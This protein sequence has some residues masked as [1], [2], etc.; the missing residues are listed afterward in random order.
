MSV[1][2]STGTPAR[3]DVR[4]NDGPSLA[5]WV[6][7]SGPPLVLVHGSLADHTT[8]QPFVAALRSSVTTFSMDRRGF[9]GSGDGD[10]YTIEQDFADV[11]AVV[12]AVAV[13]TGGP[14]ALFGH[15]YGAGCAMGAATLTRNA[16]HLVLYEPG[17]G[18]A[19]RKG[20]IEA[21]EAALDAGDV[22]LAIHW[23][24][25]GILEQTEEDFAALRSSDRWPGLVA[26]APTMA[27]EARVEDGWVYHPG[28]FD[29]ITVPTLM[30]AGSESTPEIA[31]TTRR[32][33]VAI[34]GARVHMLDGHAHLAHKTD[35]AMIAAVV[36]DFI[37]SG[38]G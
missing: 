19:Y 1:E 5:V 29:V 14:V 25:V 37:Q 20:Q 31:E 36:L 22:E 23:L 7:G 30:L 15:S 18:L 8:F 17:L 26:G 2:T 11:A 35:P 6:D 33:G 27:R 34:P 28:Q 38:G 13:R 4:V 9:G 12:D 24:Y 10:E 16:H 21:L 32:A 3:F